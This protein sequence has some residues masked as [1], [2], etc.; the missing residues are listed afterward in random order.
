MGPEE[1]PIDFQQEKKKAQGQTRAGPII[2]QRLVYAEQVRGESSVEMSQTVQAASEAAADAIEG[3]Q[4]PR[5]LHAAV[6]HY[7]GR[8]D[9]SVKAEKGVAPPPPAPPA[10]DGEKKAE[11]KK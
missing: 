4:V 5:E 9:A 10:K 3:M 1:E 7:F 8:L 11:E 2:G 6:K